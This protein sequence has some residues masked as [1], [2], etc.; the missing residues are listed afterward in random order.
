[1]NHSSCVPNNLFGSVG[2]VL[3]ATATKE[4]S[5]RRA[6]DVGRVATP[7]LRFLVFD[8]G[9]SVEWTTLTPMPVPFNCSRHISEPG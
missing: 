4:R 9:V 5:V 8:F 3:P 2:P 7:L 1:M 6:I